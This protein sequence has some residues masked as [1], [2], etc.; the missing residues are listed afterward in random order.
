MPNSVVKICL[1]EP[2]SLAREFME[3]LAFYASGGYAGIASIKGDSI[4]V[5]DWP[6]FLGGLK[7]AVEYIEK[8][9]YADGRQ[10]M[11]L[12][13]S[14]NDRSLLGKVASKTRYSGGIEVLEMVRHY[15]NQMLHLQVPPDDLCAEPDIEAPA[16][17]KASYYADRRR[18]YLIPEQKGFLPLNYHQVMMGYVGAALCKLGVTPGKKNRLTFYLLVERKTG[19][20]WVD[21]WEGIEKSVRRFLRS[22]VFREGEVGKPTATML[23]LA[24]L[25]VNCDVART[26]YTTDFLSLMVTQEAGNRATVF[27]RQPLGL[28]NLALM[29]CDLECLKELKF[30]L[31]VIGKAF[32]DSR[33][34]RAPDPRRAHEALKKVFEKVSEYLLIYSETCNSDYLYAAV[35]TLGEL[36]T[37]RDAKNTSIRIRGTGEEA[38]YERLVT[39]ALRAASC[40]ARARCG[41]QVLSER[42]L[43]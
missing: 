35:R 26:A 6:R 24:S 15:V 28:T 9:F 20:M 33:L 3:Q 31:G 21:L 13:A 41:P 42:L 34:I 38:E 12:W 10:V 23:L 40:L 36:P 18:N 5:R 4:E 37:I 2:G 43:T 8:K 22:V 29:I 14:P 32:L 39:L 25:E 30:C 27:S 11:G 7:R 16:L 19:S 1:P 17:L